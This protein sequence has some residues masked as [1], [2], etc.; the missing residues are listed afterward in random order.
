MTPLLIHDGG[1]GRNE[2]EG[3]IGKKDQPT[4]AL[5]APKPITKDEGFSVQLTA[6]IYALGL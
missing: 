2:E 1:Y 4:H 3:Q 6:V 5:H